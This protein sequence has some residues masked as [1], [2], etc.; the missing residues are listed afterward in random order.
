V[1]SHVDKSCTAT[2]FGIDPGNSLQR[3]YHSAFGTWS[4]PGSWQRAAAT[5]R[6]QPLFRGLS[7]EGPASEAHDSDLHASHQAMNSEILAHR[8][9]WILQIEGLGDKI[10]SEP[11]LSNR[12]APAT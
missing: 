6:A 4:I 12:N 11:R 8:A 1:A 10:P 3:G 2:C 7:R 5:S 9:D